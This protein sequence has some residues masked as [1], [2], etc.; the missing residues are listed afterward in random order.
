MTPRVL[1]S[2]IDTH[3][4]TFSPA[5]ARS[6]SATSTRQPEQLTNDLIAELESINIS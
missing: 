2:L 6:K 1:E 3:V 5:S 4:E